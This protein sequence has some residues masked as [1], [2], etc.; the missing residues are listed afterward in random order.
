MA[1]R[2]LFGSDI[3]EGGLREFIRS[4]SDLDARYKAM[5]ETGGRGIYDILSGAYDDGS[6]NILS[7]GLGRFSIRPLVDEYM[8]WRD[9]KW[10]RAAEVKAFVEKD[11]ASPGR[12]QTILVPGDETSKIILGGSA[13]RKATNILGGG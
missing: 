8:S 6:G 10:A 3:D 13:S 4:S 5:R 1:G 9:K 2:S 11:A 12:K 7:N